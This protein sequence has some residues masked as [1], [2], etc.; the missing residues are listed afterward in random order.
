[1]RKGLFVALLALA[2]CSQ[3]TPPRQIQS[4]P[5]VVEAARA[6]LE[7]KIVD[8]FGRA[9]L[10]RA[11][12]APEF[13]AALR[14][15]GLPPPPFDTDGHPIKPHYPTALLFRE[16]GR[17]FAYGMNGVEP[18]LPRWSDQLNGLLARPELWAEPA[19]GGE[20]GCTDSGA[21]YAWLRVAGHPEQARIGHCGGSPL[22]EQ[23]VSAAFL[24]GI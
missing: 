24:Q 11:R 13:I 3:V 20:V 19:D 6:D 9:A 18:V 10:A 15:Q 8:K 17:W 4:Q 12:S 23:L 5:P 22:T 1:M 2:G 7:Q 14:Y 21:S 16:N